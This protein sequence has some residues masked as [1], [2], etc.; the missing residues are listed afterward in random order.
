MSISDNISK[1][2]D[3]I[4]STSEVVLQSLEQAAKL[5]AAEAVSKSSKVGATFGETVGGFQLAVANVDDIVSSVPN[6]F[7]GNVLTETHIG[8][9][10]M[11]SDV[12]GLTNELV[13]TIEGSTSTNLQKISNNSTLTAAGQ[14]D[15]VISAPFPDAIA[16]AT[17]A[18]VPNV[19][20]AQLQ[21]ITQTTV[22]VSTVQLPPLAELVSVAG[23]FNAGANPLQDLSS[24]LNQIVG[25]VVTPLRTGIANIKNTAFGTL[26][27]LVDKANSKANFGFGSLIENVIEESIAPTTALL[28]KVARKNNIPIQIPQ[29]DIA[30]VTH[31]KSLGDVDGA[32]KALKK[33]SDASD[34]QLLDTVLSIDNSLSKQTNQQPAVSTATS[35]DGT[36]TKNLWN[37]GNPSADYWLYSHVLD[38]E[39]KQEL[40]KLTRPV[41]ELI[42]GST[43]SGND[44][45]TS[46][47]LIFNGFKYQTNKIIPVHYLLNEYANLERI[48]PVD[49][50]V[51]G[52]QYTDYLQNGH[53]KNSIVLWLGGGGVGPGSSPEEKG[54]T[55]SVQQMQALKNI[56]KTVYETIP[57][58]QVIGAVD[59]KS[60][61]GS[62][63]F[64]VNQFT[65]TNFNKSKIDK[66]LTEGPYT[67]D[68]I[69]GT[70]G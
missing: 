3:K 65:K 50:E 66:D 34:E 32:T 4:G 51:D 28:S 6:S 1:T 64:D 17:K 40:S 45:F 54:P 46:G 63:Y 41:T 39:L 42:I 49:I 58:I 30:V 52:S 2:M 26:T 21:T 24:A 60:G 9:V 62:P 12:P 22:D 35:K 31:L 69:S 11:V 15:V 18:A 7:P 10:N 67:L 55:Y 27:S 38:G 33:Y 25:D 23:Q 13:K 59:T 20:K 48:V 43:D 61:G 68:E 36:S 37:S 53:G 8:I 5:Q 16:A 14:L 57:G 44:I 19:T 29:A 47:E 70:K 56:L